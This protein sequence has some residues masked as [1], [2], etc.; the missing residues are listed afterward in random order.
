[1]LF[2]MSMLGLLGSAGTWLLGR[3]TAWG[4][5]AITPILTGIGNAVGAI[6]TAVAEIIASLAQSPE[7]RVFLALCA[8]ALCF[9]FIRFHYI[10][11]GKAAG[12]ASVKPIVQVQKVVQKVQIPA[13]CPKP[14][15]KTSKKQ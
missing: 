3:F 2:G 14:K 11:E 12:I 9:L 10:E 5:G 6:I 7:G 15:V 4:L 13:V 1:M 8:A